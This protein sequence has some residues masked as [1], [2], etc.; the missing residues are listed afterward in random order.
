MCSFKSHNFCRKQLDAE[1][2]KRLAQNRGEKVKDSK[3][4]KK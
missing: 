4:D 2:E 3:K 1:R